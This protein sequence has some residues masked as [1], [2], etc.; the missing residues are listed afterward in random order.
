MKVGYAALAAAL[1]AGVLAIAEPGGGTTAQP[2]APKKPEAAAGNPNKAEPGLEAQGWKAYETNYTPCLKDFPIHTFHGTA[3]TLKNVGDKQVLALP[4]KGK[5][6]VLARGEEFAVEVDANGDGNFSKDER[7]KSNGSACVVNICY[8]DG[9]IAPY[10]VRFIKGGGA[11]WGWQR[12]GYWMA[13][14]NKVPVAILDNNNNGIY[15]ENGED[16]VSV[17]LNGYATPLSAVINVG[18][19]LQQ[20]KV[21]ANGKKIWVK[22]FEGEVGKLDALSGHKS[23]GKLASAVFQNGQ[24]WIDATSGKEKAMAVPTGS[25][26]LLG[27]AVM[28]ATQS[29]MMRKGNMEPVTV[30]KDETAK[31]DWGMG[32]KI[33][34]DFDVNGG[35]VNIQVESVHVYG[36]KGEEYHTFTPPAF[37]P[38]VT[39]VNAKTNKPAQKGK[40]ALC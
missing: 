33:D 40:M 2:E 1:A 10:A 8:E 37:T 4:M 21:E 31:V 32:L 11:S 29:A 22:E 20:L 23:L 5:D 7:Y 6:G 30:A 16:A 36:Q 3:A 39:V 14:V 35:T 34:F 15:D 26:E 25:W 9:T 13:M 18:G 24:T 28:S 19:T 12:S 38:V 27:G 17:G